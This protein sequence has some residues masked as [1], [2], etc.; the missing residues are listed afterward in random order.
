MKQRFKVGDRVRW[1][2]EAGWVGGE[3]V[4]VHTKDLD[5]KGYTHHASKDDPPYEIK[6]RLDRSRRAAQGSGVATR[7]T[8]GI[9]DESILY[10]WAFSSAARRLHW[11][12]ERRRC[13]A[14]GRRARHSRSRTNPQYNCNTLSNSLS[15]FHIGYEHIAELGG[16]RG[17][18]PNVPPATNAYWQNESFHNYAD[19][20][21]GE[22]FHAG[23][24]RLQQ[25]GHSERCGIMCAETLWWQCHRRI[26][27]DYLI[28][29]GEAV[30]HILGPAHVAQAFM[31]PTA[32]LGGDGALTYSIEF[33]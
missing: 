30:F 11:L 28:A 5:F 12:A 24:K 26:I 10:D 21:M 15:G 29:D 18:Q 2:S 14:R 20:A 32:K 13:A 22:E 27:S 6:E 4:K 1:K 23:L 31:T 33:R 17:R 19:Y 8:L 9:N 7:W 16:R 3:I 25:L